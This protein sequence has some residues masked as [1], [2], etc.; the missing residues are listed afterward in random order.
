MMGRIAGSELVT[1]S[2]ESLWR[3]DCDSKQGQ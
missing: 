1:G 2:V 3:I